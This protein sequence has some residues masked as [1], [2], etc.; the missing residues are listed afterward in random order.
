MQPAVSEK[1]KK[2]MA[3]VTIEGQSKQTCQCQPSH[4]SGL[5]LAESRQHFGWLA[6][7]WHKTAKETNRWGRGTIWDSGTVGELASH[8]KAWNNGGQGGDAQNH[9]QRLDRI[10]LL[11]RSF[12]VLHHFLMRRGGLSKRTRS[13]QRGST[14]Q[15]GTAARND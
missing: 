8:K 12:P 9:T 3:K 15:R 7:R 10:L 14:V 13:T 4:A 6:D 11:F 5:V 1:Q 2:E